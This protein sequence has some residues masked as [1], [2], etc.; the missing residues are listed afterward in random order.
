MSDHSSRLYFV[1]ALFAGFG[2]SAGSAFADAANFCVAGDACTTV[3]VENNASVT[4]LSVNITQEQG[5]GSCDG[6]VKKMVTRNRAGGTNIDPGQAFRFSANS[7]C[8]YKVSF[9]TTK[10]CAGDK[11]THIRPSD[12]AKARDVVKLQNA[13]GTLN[14]RVSATRQV[15][16]R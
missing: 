11:T 15:G 14:A 7:I 16:T 4:V 2:L 13:C 6:G 1:A 5:D 9:N 3:Y 12:F 10:G 8:K